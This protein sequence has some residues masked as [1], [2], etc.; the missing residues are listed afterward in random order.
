MQ[1]ASMPVPNQQIQFCTS[2]DGTRIAYA[3]CGSG[4]PLLWIG[5]WIRHLELDWE[6][7]VWRPWLS[8]LTRRHT[9]I[10]YDWRGC[11]L[12]DRDGIQFSLKKH[13]EDLE[14][15][16]AAA[17]LDRFILFA[18]AGGA[19]MSMRYV[20]RHLDRVSRLVLYG[21]QTR[22]P[23]A[24]GMNPE[25]ALETHVHFKMVEL[26]WDDD[27][28]AYRQFLTMLHMP[29]A[30]SD[31]LRK[32]DDLLRRTTSPSNAAALLQAFFEADV[33]DDIPEIR[34]PTLVLHAREDAIIPF[35]EGRRVASLIP[36]A[37]FVPLESR[38]HLLLENEPAW[39]Q[40]VAAI[41][42]FLPGGALEGQGFEDLTARE[43]DIVELMAQGL[44]NGDIAARLK[45]ADKTVRNHVSMI[46]SK[47]SV[48][49]RAQTVAQ[50]RAA[51]FGHRMV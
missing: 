34:C 29:D 18:C 33:L 2:R 25:T 9:V 24:R 46:F 16:V 42:A 13:V 23:I 28:P 12:S 10:R 6:N 31:L 45:I 43:R 15:V 7:P 37:Q 11:G 4:P 47:L 5:H 21:S 26:G 36:G 19:T 20:S 38:N 35:D 32:Y 49:S 27:R 14:A 1:P 51:G 41:A 44:D 8:L 40:F 3:R 48:D 30:S 17:G 39:K 22:G 50:A